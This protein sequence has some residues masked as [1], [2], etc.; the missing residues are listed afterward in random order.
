MR[1]DFSWNQALSLDA[2][3]QI[4]EIANN[5][6]RDDLEVTTQIL[7]VDEARK[8]GA[9]ALFG[10]K[11][12]DVVRMVDIGGPWSRELC[13]GTHVK[14]SSNIGVI[15]VVGESS[16]SS[17][18]RRI[19]ALVGSAAVADFS[20]E[21]SIMRRLTQMLKSP[22]E[23]V[24]ERVGELIDQ[25]K[26]LEKAIS[27]ASADQA[28]SLVPNLVSKAKTLGRFTTVIETVTGIQSADEVRSITQG[29]LSSVGEGPAV[30]V[31]GSTH[32]GRATLVVA[33]NEHGVAAGA[34]AGAMVKKA[35]TL[36]GGG[37]GGKPQLAQGGGP[38]GVELE[39]TLA[40]LAGDL[41]N[42]G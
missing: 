21:K 35:S 39:A 32:E 8:A 1:L 34:N 11:Y 27:K 36:L 10:E 15:T 42:L 3:A 30:V 26:N 40:T 25:V 37:G 33:V 24:P 6:I 4:G 2:E 12:G 22:R 28:A 41:E 16:V 31:I 13:A 20:V 23:D 17:T 5:A 29:V 38:H 7:P 14:R 19:E 9:M 18:A